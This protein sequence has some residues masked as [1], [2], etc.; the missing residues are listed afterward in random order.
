MK[1]GKITL[2]FGK[3]H[4]VFDLHNTL[5]YPCSSDEDCMRIDVID[6]LIHSM[7]E[8]LLPTNSPLECA[9]L[10]KHVVGLSQEEIEQAKL[11]LCAS[12]V[13][14]DQD[15]AYLVIEKGELLEEA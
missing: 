1:E 11:D 6:P 2:A 9:L 14:E 12:E 3:E 5:K 13:E 10:N 8:H 15:K 4:V 7:H